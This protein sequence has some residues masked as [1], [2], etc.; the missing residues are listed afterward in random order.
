MESAVIIAD[1]QGKGFE[2]ARGVYDYIC[3]KEGEEFFGYIRG[4]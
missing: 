1:S 2:F 3:R 4:Y